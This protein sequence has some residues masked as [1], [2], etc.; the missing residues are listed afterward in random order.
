MEKQ[1]TP[2]ELSSAVTISVPYASQLLSG[3]REPSRPL[4]IHIYRKTGWLHPR[5]T[6]LT[7]DQMATLEELEPW[8]RAA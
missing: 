8:G 5:I 7:E 4:A 2:T 3:A 1:L 6:D